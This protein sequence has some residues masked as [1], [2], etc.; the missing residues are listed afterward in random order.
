MIHI[1]RILAPT[2]FSESSFA[3]AHYALELAE[4]LGAELHLLYVIEPPVYYSPAFGGYIPDRTDLQAY[5]AA[6]L[7]GMTIA[8]EPRDVKIIRRS[9]EGVAASTIIEDAQEHNIDMIVIGT[10]GHSAVRRFFMGSVAERVVRHASCPV[11]AV[12]PT[13]SKVGV[14]SDTGGAADVTNGDNDSA[15]STS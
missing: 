15:Q 5:A 10:H 12:R 3:A 1:K 7:E 2:D 13:T 8:D 9:V 4:A 6:G 14:E 11:L